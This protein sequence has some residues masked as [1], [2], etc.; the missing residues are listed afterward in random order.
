MSNQKIGIY[1]FIA[2]PLFYVIHKLMYRKKKDSLHPLI[3]ISPEEEF[4][5]TLYQKFKQTYK[6]TDHIEKYNENIDPV[7]FNIN[8]LYDTI[9]S[10]DS[11]LELRW[12]RR[13]LFI[14]TPRGNVIMFYDAYKQGFAYYSDQSISYPILNTCAMKYIITYRCRDFFIDE[15]FT[16]E[17]FPSRILDNVKSN[18]VEE[19][20]KEKNSTDKIDT[21]KG[22]FAKFKSYSKPSDPI[23]ASTLLKNKINLPKMNVMKPIK[24]LMQNKFIYLGKTM[25][26]SILTKVSKK[27][28]I[29]NTPSKLLTDLENNSRVQT[30][31]FSYKDFKNKTLLS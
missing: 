25:N 15:Q 10:C 23:I 11:E 19:N 14:F 27:N 24:E 29:H 8:D 7:F 3:T 30:S 17:D 20:N 31:V 5:N 9:K 16:P 21:K 6:E 1:L 13:V 28:I 26:C 22:P 2:I 12:R 4:M 18:D